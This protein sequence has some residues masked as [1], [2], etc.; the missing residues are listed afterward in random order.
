MKVDLAELLA[1]ILALLTKSKPEAS[2]PPAPPSAPTQTPSAPVPVPR[3]TTGL[4]SWVEEMWHDWFK[5]VVAADSDWL[6][7]GT[8]RLNAILSGEEN[9]P[10]GVRVRF[11]AEELPAGS[12]EQ[13]AYPIEHVFEL[14][15]ETFVVNS[16]SSEDDQPFGDL[17]HV[18]RGPRWRAGSGWDVTIQFRAWEG[19][20]RLL[21]YKVRSPED[22][23]L[24]SA[25]AS[26]TIAR[27]K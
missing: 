24:S 2:Q 13:G 5:G 10:P 22:S 11:M 12:H 4:T 15:G 9:A 23:S 19:E 17:A 20:P 16:T 6:P 7:G 8:E 26:F 3:V 25:P 1:A 21:T 14:G 18:V 27:K